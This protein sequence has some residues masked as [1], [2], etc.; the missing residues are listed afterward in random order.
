MF[1]WSC[2]QLSS[3][4][5]APFFL[6]W[7]VF[8]YGSMTSSPPLSMAALLSSPPAFQMVGK[9]QLTVAE[10]DADEVSAPLEGGSCPAANGAAVIF[11][12]PAAC[13]CARG[14]AQSSSR[15][16]AG[17]W[18]KELGRSHHLLID[19][20]P[21]PG[22]KQHHFQIQDFQIAFATCWHLSPASHEVLTSRGFVGLLKPPRSLFRLAWKRRGVRTDVRMIWHWSRELF[23]GKLVIYF[24]FSYS[25]C[26]L[27]AD[28]GTCTKSEIFG[29]GFASILEKGVTLLKFDLLCVHL[30]RVNLVVS[31]SKTFSRLYYELS[32]SPIT[33]RGI[34]SWN[35]FPR[36]TCMLCE[37]C[38]ALHSAKTR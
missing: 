4:N 38:Q 8:V 13:L 18:S 30:L 12:S 32:E 37:E 10:G 19:S 5:E 31:M 25:L 14:D 7:P 36:A 34:F 1:G 22:A 17:W 6:T 27:F 24:F 9:L 21:H 16:P 35:L 29:K 11:P 20:L 23:G 26:G 15:F 28:C 2:L 3:I 33:F